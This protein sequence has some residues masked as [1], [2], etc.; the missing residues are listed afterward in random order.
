LKK[1][2]LI[3]TLILILIAAA[4]LSAQTVS[5]DKSSLTFA[6][7]AGG[8]VQSTSLT[9][10]AN[11]STGFFG[12]SN[13]PWLKLNNG[14]VVS[15]S[16]LPFTFTVTADPT[17]LA[18]GQYFGNIALQGLSG[19]ILNVQVTFSIGTVGVDKTSISFTYQTN[20]A[21]PPAVTLNLTASSNIG[22]S[23]GATYTGTGNWLTLPA[24][25]VAPGSLQVALNGAVVVN[26]AA[27]TYNGTITIT[28]A[29]G[30]A[31]NVAVTLTVTGPPT[32]ALNPTSINLV[33]QRNGATGATNSA[34]QTLTFSNPGTAD[35]PFQV[36]PV[37]AAGP[38]GWLLVSPSASGTIPAKG[39]ATVTISYQTTSALTPALYQASLAVVVFGAANSQ[40]SIPV[41]LLVADSPLLNVPGATLAFSY[42][43]GGAAPAAKNVTVTSTA[44]DASASTG[45]TPLLLSAATATGGPW[46]GVPAQALTGTAF[47]ISVNVTGLAVGTYQG[48]ITINGVG[49]ANN[50]QTIAVTLTVSNDPL[51]VATF[52]GCSSLNTT[53]PMNFAI[54]TGQNNTTSQTVHVASSNT[55]AIAFTPTAAMNTNAACGTSWL[56]VGSVT[57]GSADST[58]PVNVTPGTIVS[59]TT[60]TGTVTI[61]ATNPANG[62]ALPNSPVTIPVTMYVSTSPMLVV[63]PIALNFTTSTSSATNPQQTLTVTS[64][65]ADMAFTASGSTVPWLLVGPSARNTASGSNAVTV[66]L[67]PNGLAPGT[68]STTI[69]MTASGALNSPLTVPITLNVT[70]ANMSVTPNTLSFS[71]TL[72]GAAPPAKNV[73]V[74]TDTSP[75]TFTTSVTMQQGTGWL[76]A[77]AS[78][79]TTTTASPA[80]VAVSV[81]GNGLPAGSYNGTVT[82]TSTTSGT[83]GSPI[84]IPVTFVVAPGTLAVDKTTLTFIQP[85]AGPAPATQIINVTGT[86]GVLPFTITP[87]TDN[88]GNWLTTSI[89][90]GNTNAAVQVNANAGNLAQG[91][92]T[93]KLTITSTGAA[94]SPQVV[95]VVMN[96]VQPQTLTV[97]P[98]T[99]NFSYTIGATT[100]P[101]TQTVQLSSSAPAPFTTT[102]T[103][104]GGGNWL[105]VTPSSGNTNATLT[106]AVNVTGL[107]AGNYTGTVAINSTS[108][109]AQPASSITVNLTVL[110]VPKPLISAIQNAASAVTGAV[111]AGE[112]IVI[113]GSGIGPAS[114]TLGHITGNTYDTNLAQTRVLFDGV[115]APIIYARAD[116]TSVM[117]PYGVAGRANTNVVVE[118]QGVQSNPIAFNLVPATPGI[119]TLNQA[120][121]GQGAIVNYDAAGNASINAAANPAGRGLVV[122]VYMTGEGTAPGSIDG[123]IAPSNGTGLFKPVLPVTATIGG[124]TASVEYFGSA[125][126]IVYGV[127]QVNLRIPAN[128]PTGAAVPLVINVGNNP[129]QTGASQVTLAIN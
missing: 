37:Y 115:A 102:A 61:T 84:N 116:Q 63:N 9:V 111:A 22:Y 92:Y 31:V 128:A 79:T 38:T 68:Y 98:S 108:S 10:S 113:Y 106:V 54:Q 28:P 93:G 59:G 48:T 16:I 52:G 13:Q 51:V 81:N 99:L 58:F 124:V 118:F 8:S 33:Y 85:Q 36:Q 120:G 35:L 122:A 4:G 126:G 47:S 21:V 73:T 53:C 125:P 26:L 129:T 100:N 19:P 24:N 109:A 96:V 70:A 42:Q 12:S 75:I 57:A 39:T 97:S 1:I 46:L 2:N 14:S 5:V 82:V 65:G 103:T 76:F 17:G 87:S 25:G 30:P 40:T 86:P 55:A 69:T 91:T 95:N 94:G 62:N 66:V 45:Q 88:G 43:L 32:V 117:V 123:G 60:C 49:A 41:R 15:S 127:M 119:Y 110:A 112:N 80:T 107:T 114:L 74:N 104:T 34:S 101:A 83:A 23:V 105:S 78:N 7:G 3:L 18:A 89:G 11:G 56:S 50:P 20:S 72:G 121:S 90:N 44:V 6:A 64:T 71:Q 67:V 27:G 29:S 77:T